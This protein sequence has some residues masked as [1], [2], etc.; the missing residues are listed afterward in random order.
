MTP[1]EISAEDFLLA[2]IGKRRDEFIGPIDVYTRGDAVVIERPSGICSFPIPA[3]FQ[4][5]VANMDDI[6]TGSMSYELEQH[7]AKVMAK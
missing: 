4:A 6:L 2:V 5:D 1:Y 3:Q 7:I